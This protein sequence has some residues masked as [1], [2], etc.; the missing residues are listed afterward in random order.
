[1]EYICAIIFFIEK[2]LKVLTVVAV[3]SVYVVFICLFKAECSYH[4]QLHS[5]WIV[6]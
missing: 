2:P 6:F 5:L 4:F 3:Y 1:M